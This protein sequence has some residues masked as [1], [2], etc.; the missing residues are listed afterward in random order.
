MDKSLSHI[1]RICIRRAKEGTCGT[2]CP[3]APA[4]PV[5]LTEDPFEPAA[6]PT[7]LSD[8][9]FCLRVSQRLSVLMSSSVQRQSPNCPANL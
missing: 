5:S 2:A 8:L 9:P 1:I 6:G 4:A 7:L 3:Q